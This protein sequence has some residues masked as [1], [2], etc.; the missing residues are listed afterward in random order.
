MESEPNFFSK[1]K[2]WDRIGLLAILGI[3]A[4]I[5]VIDEFSYPP[6][7]PGEINIV[8]FDAA[9]YWENRTHHYFNSENMVLISDFKRNKVYTLIEETAGMSDW[10]LSRDGRNILYVTKRDW[11]RTGRWLW[12]GIVYTLNM[13]DISAGKTKKLDFLIVDDGNQYSAGVIDMMRFIKND[14]CIF[15]VNKGDARIFEYNIYTGGYKKVFGAETDYMPVHDI[16]YDEA[17]EGLFI[18]LVIDSQSQY[19]FYSPAKGEMQKI[20]L[21]KEDPGWRVLG[22]NSVTQKVYFAEYREE[23]AVGYPSIYNLYEFDMARK[24]LKLLRVR[25]GFGGYNLNLNCLRDGRYLWGEIVGDSINSIYCY[26]LQ[27]KKYTIYGEG[28]ADY[29]HFA[30][31]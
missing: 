26:D 1:L 19:Y 10:A 5:S 7:M 17:G 8:N 3:V 21:P 13:T 24:E 14:S 31:K 15:I 4:I 22:G 20:E 16:I 30:T 27:N 6:D 18:Y 28:S 23:N 12:G 2:D 9:I 29:L 25:F 11:G